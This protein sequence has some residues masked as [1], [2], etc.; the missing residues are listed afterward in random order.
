MKSLGERLVAGLKNWRSRKKS[1][2]PDEVVDA[3]PA[4]SQ[5]PEQLDHILPTRLSIKVTTKDPDQGNDK[6][7]GRVEPT[8][9]P[10]MLS[11]VEEPQAPQEAP[12]VVESERKE[13]TDE[14]LAP[15]PVLKSPQKQPRARKPGP[16]TEDGPVTDEV[17]EELEAENARLRLLLNERLKAK[18][19]GS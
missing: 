13:G 15:P 2:L 12:V 19:E 11:P 14:I 9:F 10:E 18:Q 1:A 16:K 6:T 4:T 3:D 7:T 17:L 5:S 8:D